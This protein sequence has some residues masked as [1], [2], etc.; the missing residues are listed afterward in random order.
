[1]PNSQTKDIDFFLKG[2]T[3]RDKEEN[4]QKNQGS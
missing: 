3:L 2:E 1:M 4:T